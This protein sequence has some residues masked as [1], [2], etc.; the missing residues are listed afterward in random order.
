MT[1]VITIFKILNK[2]RTIMSG[3]Q[4]TFRSLKSFLYNKK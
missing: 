2:F 1:I 4:E 3:A